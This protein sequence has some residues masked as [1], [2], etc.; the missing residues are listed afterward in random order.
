M[1]FS[2]PANT[3]TR[4]SVVG[5]EGMWV[6]MFD[7]PKESPV[8]PDL[9]LP[10]NPVPE[11]LAA[12]G[13]Q[14]APDTPHTVVLEL[15]HGV[16]LDTWDRRS[17]GMEFF[18]FMNPDSNGVTG[19][20]FPSATLRLPQGVVFHCETD[21]K[22]PPPHTI[23]WHGHEPTP[24]NDGVGHCSMEIGH[25]IYQL[26]PQ[27]IG[28]YFSHCHRN[29]MQHFEFGLY[30]LMLVEPKDAYFATQYN[31][32]IPIGHCRDGKRRTAANVSAFPQ[33]PGFNANPINA[34]DPWTGDVRLKFNTDPH[35]HTV[36]YDIEALWVLDDRDSTWSDLANNARATYP[37]HGTRPGF[38]DNFHFNGENSP[39]AA[40][41]FFAFNDFNAD[42]W[43]ITGVPVR[44]R[45][46]E[47]AAIEPNI[48]IPAA[49][50]SGVSGS[51]VSINGFTGQTILVRCLDAAYNSTEV[52]FPV[53]V[54]IIAWDGRALGVAPF[55]ENHA[56]RVP[57][58]TP[59]K[60]TTAR[61][62]DA[63]LR[64]TTAL[65]SSATVKFINTRGQLPGVAQDVVCTG[66]IPIKIAKVAPTGTIVINGGAASTNVQSV[67]LTLTASSVAGSVT[68][69]Q[70]SKDGGVNYFAFE[71]FATT[72][73]VTLLPGEGLKS[74]TVRFRDSAGNISLP[75]SDSIT[76]STGSI[77]IN[78]GATITTSV[79]ATLTLSTSLAGVNQMQFS[80]NGTFW[81]GWENYATT[82]SVTLTSAP[83][84]AD[85]VKTIH[86]RFRNG[87][88]VV[89]APISDNIILDR[90]RPTGTIAFTTPNPTSSASATLA[91]SASDAN[92]VT[93]MQFSKNGSGFYAWEPYA[94]SR[95]VTLAPGLN[96]LTVRF[97]DAAGNLSLPVSATIVRS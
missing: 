14:R 4:W 8:T 29:T 92:G 81:Y 39:A 51:Q 61:R 33:F 60:M 10:T 84:E 46:G 59:I 64:V 89:T 70:F 54:V 76:L 40:N 44:A 55:G 58:G 27:F 42:Y 26:Q 72:R 41:D 67:T 87:A 17:N 53:D 37:M 62:F 34:L 97:R 56:Y 7:P 45:K 30:F 71:Q 23:H 21:G 68:Q 11:V 77:L 88:G 78:G 12:A 94:T 2:N 18:L 22:G 80:K 86:V 35:A 13:F 74:V 6:K 85:G 65:D 52:T 43:Y 25:Y 96:T 91:L 49:L 24:M 50:N 79:T 38:N 57:A 83:G 9:V 73:T 5:M 36:P 1:S 82:R 48:V 15:M 75:I 90:T 28:T 16:R 31:P 3:I 19:N 95:T 69:M 63:L 20:E 47:T 66:R 32:A 93:Q